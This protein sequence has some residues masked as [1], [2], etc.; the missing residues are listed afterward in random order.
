[1]IDSASNMLLD[2]YVIIIITIISFRATRTHPTTSH[3]LIYG[4]LTESKVDLPLKVV[5]LYLL[6]VC[7]L[8]MFVTFRFRRYYLWMNA[9]QMFCTTHNMGRKFIYLAKVVRLNFTW[10]GKTV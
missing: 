5:L 6:I 2:T 4:S 1:M 3:S 9:F 8:R 7:L 10:I